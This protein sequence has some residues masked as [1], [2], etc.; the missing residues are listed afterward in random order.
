M[1]EKSRMND[2]VDLLADAMRQVFTETVKDVV[3]P[4]TTEVKA[5][6]SDMNE[7]RSDVND[8]KS[9]VND[10]KKE[11]HT[12]RENVQ[13][14]LAEHRKEVRNIL[15]GHKPAASKNNVGKSGARKSAI[16]KSATKETVSAM[17]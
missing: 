7:L 11:N 12:T 6:R 17:K 9:D 13:S 3:E 8:L 10:L 4:L 2:G 16:R 14:Q 15:S 1:E 5:M